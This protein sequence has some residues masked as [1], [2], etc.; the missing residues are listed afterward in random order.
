MFS[1]FINR[2][3]PVQVLVGG[4][5]VV[6]LI[7]SILL[8]LPFATSSGQFNSYVDAL[9]TAASAT[10]TTGLI[11][12]DTGTFYN[13]FGQ[14]VILTLFQ[15]GGLGYMVFIVLI[16]AGL[17]QRASLKTRVLFKEAMAGA[18]LGETV[19]YARA[20]VIFTFIFELVG[21]ILLFSV[22]R[23]D[24]PTGRA[25]YHAIFHS[26]S[27]FCTAGF[28]T[29]TTNFQAYQQSIPAHFI[30]LFCISGGIGFFV[31]Y[32]I[33]QYIINRFKGV[34]KPISLH[35]RLVI[36]A[37]ILMLIVSVLITYN[38]QIPLG[39]NLKT[40]LLVSIFQPVSALT[41]TGFST[42]NLNGM[43]LV[44][45]FILI[46]LM[47]IGPG[48]GST[49]GGIKCTSFSL[50]ILSVVNILFGRSDV[51]IF[52]RCLPRKSIDKAYVIATGA[53]TL[54]IIDIMILS[55]AEDTSFLNIVFE[56]TSA[57]ATAGLSM[58]ITAGLSVVGKI[59]L[60][61]TMLIGRVGPL[62][63]G[64]SLVGVPKPVTYR[65]SEEDVFVG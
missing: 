16:V 41:G 48:P 55:V 25:I 23:H 26:V 46:L 63:I 64:L 57:F 33:Y 12:V 20:V 11:V 37:I 19:N 21:A 45:V 56:V 18:R 28:S 50:I 29:F 6:I 43:S 51:H 36:T 13:L 40:N 24:F 42:I 62:A 30:L 59:A 49:A 5:V 4:F 60:S 9:F 47:Y 34:R 54:L 39:F 38:S 58:G 17:R 53:L 44:G 22:F 65:Y 10:T 14:I 31:L 8:S 32:D 3:T 52:K 15:M 1:R 61:L 7:G 35:S 2:L 27:A